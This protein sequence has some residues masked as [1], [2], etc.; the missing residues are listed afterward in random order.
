MANKIFLFALAMTIL[1]LSIHSEETKEKTPRSSLQ[2]TVVVT[3]TKIETPAK[4]IASS[5]TVISAEDLKKM[6][7]TTVVEVLQEVLGV[8]II[9]NGGSGTGAACSIR[10]ANSEHT[11]VL[12]DG[13]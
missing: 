13:V 12:M 10:G 11:L 8:T 1:S 3:A 6:K 4:E 5:V 7:K 9:Q 2:Y